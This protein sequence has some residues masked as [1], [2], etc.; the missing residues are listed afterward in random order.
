MSYKKSNP[1][2]GMVDISHKK[3]TQRVAVATAKIKMSKKAFN[4]L[5]QGDS[6]KGDVL[7]VA[8]VAG[9][10]AAKSTPHLI[11]MCHPLELNKVQIS[12]GL[13]KKQNEVTIR[14]EVVCQGRTGVEMEALCAVSVAA[15]TIYDMMKWAGQGMVIYDTMLLHKSG[16][17]SGEYHRTEPLLIKINL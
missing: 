3:I 17:E 13:D 2:R 10:M 16:G 14:S 1:T 9:I 11:P 15:L 5:M 6:P 4:A 7:E 12:F 8:K